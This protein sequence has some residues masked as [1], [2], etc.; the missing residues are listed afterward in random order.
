M[1]K[2]YTISML[3]AF[4][5]IPFA[6]SMEP[7]TSL[8]PQKEQ[9]F[10]S[11]ILP[12][13][14]GL[15]GETFHSLNIVNT[16]Y[17]FYRTLEDLRRID[18]GQENCIRSFVEQLE[19]DAV[20]KTDPK[21]KLLLYGVSQGTATLVNWLAQ[22]SHDEQEKITSCLVLE[23]VLGS[24]DS[25]IKH[26]AKN[27]PVVGWLPTSLLSV[28]A[29]TS[30]FP[31]YQRHG[32]NALDS[33]HKLSPRIPVILMHN[34]QDIHLSI[35]DARQL[36]CVLK[37]DNR[38]NVYLFEVDTPRA[39]VNLLYFDQ[40]KASLDKRAALQAIYKKHG[41]PYVSTYI[42]DL[43]Q[44]QPSVEQVKERM[45]GKSSFTTSFS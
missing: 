22:K 8:A 32:L 13:Q 10:Y 19:S 29:K 42:P 21:P 28:V 20:L 5:F 38:D 16:R 24:G 11:V 1:S 17:K 39:H 23:S 41:L 7:E 43:K 34:I 14:N 4:L 27:I 37:K 15:G 44:F 2:H 6:V 18:L 30:M 9:E 26:T 45:S 35:D 33:A 12:G 3:T 40:N 25:A 36:Y 31:E